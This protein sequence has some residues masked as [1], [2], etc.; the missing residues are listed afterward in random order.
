MKVYPALTTLALLLLIAACNTSSPYQP[1]GEEVFPAEKV[2]DAALYRMD[3]LPVSPGF[4][5]DR[6]TWVGFGHSDCGT[7]CSAALDQLNAIQQGQGLFVV[8]DMASHQR[9]RELGK[10]YPAVAIGMGITAMSY[11]VFA[12]QFDPQDDSERAAMLPSPV[13]TRSRPSDFLPMASMAFIKK[14][15]NTCSI[16]AASPMIGG[17]LSWVFHT[18]CL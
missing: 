3:Q 16:C 13:E 6:W 9:L 11:D 2:D 12:V 18:P 10:D 8:T 1:V 7:A 5:R 15:V 4:F 14:F 17:R